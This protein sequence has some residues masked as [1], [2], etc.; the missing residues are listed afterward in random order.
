MLITNFDVKKQELYII[1]ACHSGENRSYFLCENLCKEFKSNY[2]HWNGIEKNINILNHYVMIY[3]NKDLK[4][5]IQEISLQTTEI[6]ELNY[7]NSELFKRRKLINQ[8]KSIK[9]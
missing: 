3:K 9:V 5:S 4:Y 2:E 6:F 1:L 7:N 8:L